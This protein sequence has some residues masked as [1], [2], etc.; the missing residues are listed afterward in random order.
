MKNIVFIGLMG[1]GK[2]TI[3]RYLSDKLNRKMI[4]ADVYLEDKCNMSISEMFEI[5]EDYFREKEHLCIKEISEYDGIVISTGGGVVKNM[6]NIEL[7]KRN[8]IIIYIDRPVEKIVEDIHTQ[9]R[10]LL[11][12]GPQKLFELYNQRHSL[13]LKAC[14]YHL[15]NDSSIEDFIKKVEEVI[16]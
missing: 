1:C 11:K 3:S 8:G 2:T 13:Y 16:L 5:S 15:I 12:D 6:K 7:L 14:D 9:N 10:P 4:D